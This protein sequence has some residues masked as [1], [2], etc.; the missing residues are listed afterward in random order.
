MKRYIVRLTKQER[1]HL[2][3]VI[4]KGK[5]SAELNKK[6]RILLKADQQ[7][8][9]QWLTD[10]QIALAVDV[11]IPTVERLRKRFVEEGFEVCL[12]RSPR[13]SPA[14]NL[15]LDGRLEAHIVTLACSEPPKGSSYW[16]LQLIS[17]Q[18]VSLSY[19]DKISLST[20]YRGLKK[21]RSSPGKRSHG[22]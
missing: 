21:T 7:H 12:K 6:A 10:K 20:V 8:Q 2:L 4:R 5:S 17:D 18:L 14:H 1:S 13:K 9:D 22:V 11:S 19:V 16:T 15:K 3:G